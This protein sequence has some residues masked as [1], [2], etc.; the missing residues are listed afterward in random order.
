VSESVSGWGSANAEGVTSGRARKR[1][2]V[3]KL[4]AAVGQDQV[5]WDRIDWRACAPAPDRGLAEQAGQGGAEAGR[6][7]HGRPGQRKRSA[8]NGHRAGSKPHEDRQS[9]PGKAG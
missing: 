5:S 9:A 4:A 8:R 2:D 6:Q 1:A 7:V 3:G